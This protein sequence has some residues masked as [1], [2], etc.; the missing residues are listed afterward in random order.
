[1]AVTI[2]IGQQQ[3]QK[4]VMTQSLK[5]SIEMLQ[6]STQ[7]LAETISQ[8]LIENPVLEEDFSAGPSLSEMDGGELVSGLTQRL[9]GDD[10]LAQ[11]MDEKDL[12]YADVSDGGYQADYGDDDRKRKF[13]ENMVAHRESLTEHLLSQGRIASKS[14][15]EQRLFESIITAIDERGLLP[16]P[17]E[18]IAREN[19][20][21]EQEVRDA[22]EVIANFDPPGC[23]VPTVRESLLVQARG[24]YPDDAVL[25]KF[26][27]D[28]FSDLEKLDYDKIAR[29]LN[30][31]LQ[32]VV[33]KTKLLNTLTPYPGRQYS[34]KDIRYI[35]PDVEVQCVDGEIIITVN[36]DWVPQVRINRYYIDLLKKKNIDK[37][38]KEYI[39]EKVQ[40]ARYLMRNVSNRRDTIVRVVAAIMQHQSDFLMRGPGHL[41]P[42]THT[43]IAGEV[44]M[45]EST[46]SRV[47]SNKFVQTAWG[48]YELKY[49]FVSK[50]RSSNDEQYSSEKVI[51]LIKDIVAAED[52]LNPLSDDAILAKLQK[53]GI[54]LSRRTIAKYRGIVHIPPSNKRKKL[55]M[56]KS[57]AKL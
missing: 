34:M 20:V 13:I 10:S 40:S 6:L 14:E 47:T 5:Q 35:I 23:G 27:L 55:N 21:T 56:I 19:A 11:R 16:Y 18:D 32:D 49:F 17:V 41:M 48:V 2:K 22:I 38:L 15:K 36:D 28:H 1:M 53:L 44:G 7:D 45:H 54:I 4:L 12:S 8:E 31:T 9:S 39:R 24:M 46:I 33:E 3:T 50:L 51:S 29:A 57:E 42:L 26:L 25:E 43:E 37:N 30:I 52:P